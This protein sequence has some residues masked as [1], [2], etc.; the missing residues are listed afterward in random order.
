MRLPTASAWFWEEKYVVKE[1]LP[2]KA[3]SIF[4]FLGKCARLAWDWALVLIDSSNRAGDLSYW[5]PSLTLTSSC[6]RFRCSLGCV[7][8]NC[9]PSWAGELR[10]EAYD[11]L[12]R[13]GLTLAANPNRAKSAVLNSLST[14]PCWTL[15]LCLSDW[16]SVPTSTVCCFIRSL[17]HLIELLAVPPVITLARS[18]WCDLSCWPGF[19]CRCPVYSASRYSNVASFFAYSLEIWSSLIRFRFLYWSSLAV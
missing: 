8:W 13:C 1:F 11:L 5:V 6:N 16:E 4:I 3:L 10:F 18:K 7:L 2:S 15:S 17:F 9:R 14:W 19:K 12:R